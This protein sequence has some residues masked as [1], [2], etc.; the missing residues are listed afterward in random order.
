MRLSHLIQK[1]YFDP[2]CI[3]EKGH[4][5]IRAVIESKLGDEYRMEDIPEDETDLFG[6]ALPKPWDM[7]ENTKVIPVVGTIGYKI[8]KIEK[9]CGV[10][11]VRDI[12]GWMQEAMADPRIENIVLDVSSPGGGVTGVPELADYIAEC[13]EEKNIVAFTD[14]IMASAAMWI[15]AGASEVF[16][17]ST[18]DVGSIGVYSYIL[19][20]SKMYENAGVK[21]ELFKD[22]K[23]KGM[24]IQGLSLSDD[25]RGF[26][27][28]E[29]MKISALFK[30]FMRNRRPSISDETMQG[31]CLMGY[32]AAELGLVD[33][34]VESID[35]IFIK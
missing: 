15:A 26:L 21:V 9:V 6:E 20:M 13:S 22:G 29:V 4:A 12:R 8:G 34:V 25:Q 33:G 10:T 23:Y 31:Q 16:S 3:T 17:T 11:D 28:G 27:Q 18:A 2:I 30:G 14:D 24:G 1:I 19:D 32:E 35:D 5:A 7:N